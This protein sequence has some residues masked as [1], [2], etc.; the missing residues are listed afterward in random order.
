MLPVGNDVVSGI[1]PEFSSL[2]AAFFRMS[3][4]SGVRDNGEQSWARVSCTRE[5]QFGGVWRLIVKCC[6]VFLFAPHASI[7][8]PQSAA[9]KSSPKLSHKTHCGSRGGCSMARWSGRGFSHPIHGPPSPFSMP[10][11]AS[12]LDEI[13]HSLATNNVWAFFMGSCAAHTG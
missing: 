9:K 7:Q 6:H 3:S 8:T 5:A 1:Y 11:R 13:R 10:T 2:R 4:L 12:R